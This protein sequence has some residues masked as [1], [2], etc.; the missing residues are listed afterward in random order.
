MGAL[1]WIALGA[2]AV[3]LIVMVRRGTTVRRIGLEDAPGPSAPSRRADSARGDLTQEE[4]DQ[5]AEYLEAGRKL[6]AIKFVREA[7]GLGLAE[8]KNLVDAHETGAI[9]EVDAASPLGGPT[10][11]SE[12]D[13]DRVSQLLEDSR[14]I[15]AV[16]FVRESTGCGLKE[17]KDLVEDIEAAR[18][19]S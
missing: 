17:A 18:N 6:E 16:K 7:T 15:E 5:V 3:L 10:D 14:K 1:I 19:R 13:R 9:Y 2:I 12:E 11:L 8:A 4:R